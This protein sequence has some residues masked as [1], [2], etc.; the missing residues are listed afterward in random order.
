L[1]ARRAL[2]RH[3]EVEQHVLLRLR[4]DLLERLRQRRRLVVAD[5]EALC[6]RKR[7]EREQQNQDNLFQIL[8]PCFTY[9]SS[10]SRAGS[11]P[12][13]TQPAIIRADSEIESF[14]FCILL[15]NAKW[16]R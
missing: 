8:R 6:V 9:W 5:Q 16:S 12:A 2:L 10:S 15:R 13:T 4:A 3:V 11:V 1:R 14:I 7:C